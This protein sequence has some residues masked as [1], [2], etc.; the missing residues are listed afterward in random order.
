MC[1]LCFKQHYRETHKGQSRMNNTETY[2]ALG[3]RK[4]TNK[5][6][7]YKENSKDEQHGPQHKTSDERWSSRRESTKCS[8]FFLQFYSYSSPL[9]VLSV[10]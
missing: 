6:K 4:R 5:I 3:P 1:A 8:S 2:A 10:I 7:H 9:K